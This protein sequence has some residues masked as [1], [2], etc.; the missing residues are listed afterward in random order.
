M[1][2]V[3]DRKTGTKKTTCHNCG[4]LLQY[5]PSEVKKSKRYDYTGDYDIVEEIQCPVCH[6]DTRT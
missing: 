3:L 5:M 4:S 2:V 1:V 6:T